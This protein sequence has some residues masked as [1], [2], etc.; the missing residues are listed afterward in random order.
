VDQLET[1]KAITTFSFFSDN[2]QDGVNQFSTFGVV[3][4]GPI[5]TSSG[6]TEDEVI[7]SE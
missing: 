5:V 7:R 4:F 3:T 2:I 6:L 1:L